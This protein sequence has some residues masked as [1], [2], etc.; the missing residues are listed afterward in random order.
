VTT[1]DEPDIVLDK[2]RAQI[3]VLRLNRPKSLNALRH[4]TVRRL[5]SLLDDLTA[6]ESVRV[7]V[8]TGAGRGFCAGWDLESPLTDAAGEPLTQPPGVCDFMRGQELFAGM[9]KR[10]RTLDKV[11]IAAVNGVAVGAGFALTLAAD[12]RLAA[13]SASFHVGAV[14]IGLTAG[15]CGISYHL[16]RLIGASR[17]FEVMLTGRPLD[18]AEAER[19][20]LVSAVVDDEQLPDRA[21]ALADQ[22]LANSPCAT[23]HTKQLMWANLSA[24]SL[25]AAIELE[26]RAQV[27][28]LMT[29]DF[30]E[31][32]AA[33]A[34]KRAPRYS[35][36]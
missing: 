23:R 2:S 9:V 27:L 30:R 32:S 19:C 17:A 35:G 5:C 29:E 15:E 26:N 28:A 4:D 25:D 11:V 16:P 13:R 36:R 24:P 7:V 14:R 33:F 20:G 3:A 1:M 18:A 21:L 31:A 12:V 8:L 34:E 10:L 6:D 22:V